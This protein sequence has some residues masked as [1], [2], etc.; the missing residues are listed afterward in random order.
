[1]LAYSQEHIEETL[2]LSCMVVP[3][4]A[5]LQSGLHSL[6]IVKWPIMHI[7]GPHSIVDGSVKGRLTPLMHGSALCCS[8]SSLDLCHLH[9][10]FLEQAFPQH[11]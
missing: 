2:S 9:P 1:M 3:G 10:Q 7:C 5:G 4:G 11:S 8:Q 6:L